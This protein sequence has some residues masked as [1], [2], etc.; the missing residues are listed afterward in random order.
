VQQSKTTGEKVL[1][2]SATTRAANT[3][4]ESG[5]RK[6]RIFTMVMASTG[7]SGLV[8]TAAAVSWEQ[9]FS[10]SFKQEISA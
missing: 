7:G 2:G 10:R 5:A 3:S 1:T 4:T 6:K 8:D 9:Y